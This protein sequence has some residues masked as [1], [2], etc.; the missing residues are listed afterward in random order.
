MCLTMNPL[1]TIEFSQQV[2]SLH[3]AVV[4]VARLQELR[5]DTM[6]P[7]S[8]VGWHDQPLGSKLGQSPTPPFT[9]AADVTPWLSFSLQR[10]DAKAAVQ[11]KTDD[12]NSLPR[13]YFGF[14]VVAS[15]DLPISSSHQARS[16]R[17]SRRAPR[18]VRGWR[19]AC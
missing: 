2:S 6:Y 16:R 18:A 4:K 13:H 12:I 3:V 17:A 11:T 10:G 5:P 1:L 9:G 8:H 19:A 14:V 15:R 7:S